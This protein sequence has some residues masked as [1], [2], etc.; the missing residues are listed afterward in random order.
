MGQVVRFKAR[1]SALN[2]K[3][4]GRRYLTEREGERLAPIEGKSR[5]GIDGRAL[6]FSRCAKLVPHRVCAAPS[7]AK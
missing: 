2:R 5:G 3:V 6:A 4:R 7:V 1:P